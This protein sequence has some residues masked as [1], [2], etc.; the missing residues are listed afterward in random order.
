MS[1]RDHTDGAMAGRKQERDAMAE[2]VQRRAH[3]Y[4]ISG[5]P[6][7][8][9]IAAALE[10]LLDELQAGVHWRERRTA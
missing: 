2:H 8:E 4:S 9:A 10:L 7:G 1:Y 3:A 5:A 6:N